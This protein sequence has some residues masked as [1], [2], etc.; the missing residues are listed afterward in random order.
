MLN[1]AKN[2]FFL[3]IKGVAMANLALIIK[4]MGKKVSGFDVEE[5]FITDKLLKQNQ[6]DYQTDC[7]FLS[8]DIDLFIYSAAHGGLNHPLAKL[9]K[10]KKIP[11]VS[12]AQLIGELMKE[13]QIKIAVCGCHGKTTTTSLLI[14]ALKNLNEKPS[15]L[16]GAPFFQDKKSVYYGGDFEEKKYFAVEADEYGVNPP[17][18]KTP[19]FFHLHPNWIIV[20]NIDYDHPDVYKDL[21]ETVITFEKF[22]NGKN[23]VLNIDDENLKKIYLKKNNQQILTYGFSNKAQYQIINWQIDENKSWFKIKNLGDFELSLFGKHNISNATAVIALLH[24]LGFSVNKIKKAIK[25]FVG[26]KRRF[27]LIYQGDFLLFDDYAHHPQEIEKIILAARERFKNKRIIVIFQP[28]TFSRTLALKKEF[29]QSLSL[30]DKT[31]ILPIFSSARE[32]SEN[33]KITSADIAKINS[34][35]LLNASSEGE[36]LDYLV[37]FLK[38]GDIILTMGAGDVY[39]LSDKIIS[40]IKNVDQR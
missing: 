10:T 21:K 20:T 15:Y 37:K 38:T 16:V 17:I 8:S 39:Q 29:A 7:Q 3:G 26:A 32:K 22:F 2:I 6:I 24:H 4:K 40:I 13:F 36:L 9:A 1:K 14:Y 19:K 35:K 5:E 12:Q 23:L 27:E 34:D 18:D 25:N 31:I 33:F 28:H 30:A 11:L